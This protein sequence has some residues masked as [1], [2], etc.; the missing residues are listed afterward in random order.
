[1]TSMPY[2]P[3]P[4]PPG[5]DLAEL[6]VEQRDQPGDGLGTVMPR[7]DRAGARAGRGGHE[8]PADGGAESG[9]LAL[10]VADA[11]LVDLRREQRVADEFHVHRRERPTSRMTAIA[12]KIAQPWRWFFA[13]RPNV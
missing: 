11:S 8:Q 5:R 7:V 1:M 10:H 2:M 3:A 6:H 4:M 9:L 12:A 13:Y